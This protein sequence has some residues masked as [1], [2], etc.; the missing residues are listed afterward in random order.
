MPHDISLDQTRVTLLERWT[1]RVAF[2][3]PHMQQ[4]HIQAF[5][6]EAEMTSEKSLERTRG[7]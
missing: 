4:P 2:P 1:S 6:R 5:I 3:G 7:G